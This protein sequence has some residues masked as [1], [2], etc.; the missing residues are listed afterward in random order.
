M[1]EL[2]NGTKTVVPR[3]EIEIISLPQGHEVQ[4]EPRV[5]SETEP[6]AE[7]EHRPENTDTI[8]PNEKTDNKQ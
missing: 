2:D 5:A 3:E 8:D 6:L 7:N 1:V 4:E